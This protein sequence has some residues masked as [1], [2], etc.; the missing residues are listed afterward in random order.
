MK[1]NIVAGGLHKN[2]FFIDLV[3]PLF[4]CL[5][6]MVHDCT[7]LPMAKDVNSSITD[8]MYRYFFTY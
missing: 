5:C 2:H 3:T 4:Y 8:F 7:M 1:I 6:E